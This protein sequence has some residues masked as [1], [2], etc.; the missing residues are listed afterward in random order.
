MQ[1]IGASE[2]EVSA[3]LFRWRKSGSP[4]GFRFFGFHTAP[5]FPV[6]LCTGYHVHIAL[7]RGDGGLFR[8]I[9]LIYTCINSNRD[10]PDEQGIAGFAL[11][12]N[13]GRS[14]RWRSEEHTSEL[15]SR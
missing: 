7:T 2:R 1:T 6:L 4:P 14:G 3:L 11:R 15:Q 10:H 8:I 9:A 13:G 5:S 12:A